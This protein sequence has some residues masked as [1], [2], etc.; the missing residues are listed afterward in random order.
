MHRIDSSACSRNLKVAWLSRPL[1]AVYSGVVLPGPPLLH[2]ARSP[3]K[4]TAALAESAAASAVFDIFWLDPEMARY[5]DYHS[6][7]AYFAGPVRR[8]ACYGSCAIAA[9]AARTGPNPAGPARDLH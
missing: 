2:Q 4:G 7:Q 8:Y 5:L 3:S 9:M 6:D 1:V